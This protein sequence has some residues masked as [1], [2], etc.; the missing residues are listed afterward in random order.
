MPS[1]R[2]KKRMRGQATAK[3]ERTMASSFRGGARVSGS[4]AR[5]ESETQRIVAAE[6]PFGAVRLESEG[7]DIVSD[8]FVIDDKRSEGER[9]TFSRTIAAKIRQAASKHGK[10]PAIQ[11][12]FTLPIND[13]RYFNPATWDQWVCIPKAV[14]DRLERAYFSEEEE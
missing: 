9:I 4:G 1:D 6:A 14:F 11:F 10:V 12:T 5:L 3:I 13:P 2:E 8:Y 7:A